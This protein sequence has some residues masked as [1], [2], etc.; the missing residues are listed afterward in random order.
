MDSG[1]AFHLLGPLPRGAASCGLFID[2]TYLFVLHSNRVVGIFHLEFENPYLVSETLLDTT[3][4]IHRHSGISLLLTYVSLER[5][6]SDRFVV[7]LY[8]LGVLSK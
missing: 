5:Q 4:V 6:G 8:R 7:I 2:L 1:V 3:I